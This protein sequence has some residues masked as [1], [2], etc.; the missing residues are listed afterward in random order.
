VPK[1]VGRAIALLKS[2]PHEDAQRL[3]QELS[4]TGREV[5]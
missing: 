5:Q 1:D 2:T 4:A 3:L